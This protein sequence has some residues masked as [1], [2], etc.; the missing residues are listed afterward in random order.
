MRYRL[1]SA[2]MRIKGTISAKTIAKTILY[3][4]QT[5]CASVFRL[6]I[7]LP[8][9]ITQ[10]LYDNLANFILT[11]FDLFPHRLQYQTG[12]NI[13][14]WSVVVRET[15][16]TDDNAG[17]RDDITLEGAQKALR[18]LKSKIKSRISLNK[19]IN[20]HTLVRD[21]VPSTARFID[22]MQSQITHDDDDDE[23]YNQ[24]EIQI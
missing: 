19:R 24:R 13:Y 17:L 22:T 10:R 21:Q 18:M 4:P 1:S 7:N 23:N 20:V 9:S 6:S 8:E 16:T 15:T 11:N 3:N 5:P 2:P 12:E 14:V